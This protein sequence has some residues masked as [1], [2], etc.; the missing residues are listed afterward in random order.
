MSRKH[1]LAE[2]MVLSKRIEQLFAE[3]DQLGWLPKPDRRTLWSSRG[4]IVMVRE[5]ENRKPLRLP[6]D[7]PTGRSRRIAKK[8]LA[9][10]I[11]M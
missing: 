6:K 3:A 7:G 2:G 8:Q 11:S 5:F 10:L 1:E 9:K 4:S